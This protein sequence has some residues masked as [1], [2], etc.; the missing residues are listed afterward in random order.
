M[1]ERF[2]AWTEAV[3]TFVLEV[4]FEQRRGHRAAIVRGMLFVLSKGFAL[5]VKARRFLYNVRILRDTTLGVQV[6]AVGNL[7]VG[8]TGKTP[9]VEKFARELKDQGRTVAILSRGYRSKP[10]PLTK[11]LIDKVLLRE[12][13][14]PPR[15][16]SDG[17]S[18]LLDSEKAGDEP[19]M[20]ASNLRD[21]IVLVDKDRVK[22]GRYAIEKFGCDILLLDDG[23][24]YWKLRGR[25]TDIVLVDYQQPF[26][27]EQLLPRGTLRE[28]PSHLARAKWIFITKSNGKAGALRR[29]IAEN[30]PT[31]GI[32]EC[33]HHPLYFEDVFTG[34]R[35]GL[36]LFKG[37]KIASLS[38]IAQPQSFEQ[39]LV[40]LGGD[41]VYSKRFADHHRFS[42]QEVLN[43]INRGKK[44]Q[45][46]A[47]ITTQKDAVR[48]PK[49]DRR[50]VPIYFMRVE[51]KIL[52]GAKDFHD[53]VRQ[54]CFR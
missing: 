2:R 30:N 25:R 50:D 35:H 10:P 12:D 17:K 43:A 6:I 3:E 7:T 19:Y 37:R 41:L 32:I 51:I 5:A 13:R 22:S 16:V 15:V 4:I 21:V 23:F 36:D 38:G 49:I 28:P 34:E 14:T 45:A 39:S 31:A 20:L 26:G 18:L 29:R 8:G 53:C 24:Q 33:I 42:Q 1:R 40:H 52:S 48:F 44:R 9:V 54:I 27:N 46:Q 11:R 47:I